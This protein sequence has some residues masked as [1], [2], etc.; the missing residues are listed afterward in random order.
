MFGS[1]SRLG[2]LVCAAALALSV[3]SPAQASSFDFSYL[4]NDGSA[5]TG[6]LSG[7]LSGSF[8][9]NISDVHVSLNGTEFSGAHL[10]SAAWNTATQSWDNTT[11]AKISTNASLNNFILADSNVPADY[12]A[13][14]YFYFVNDPSSLGHEVFA[15]NLNTGDIALDNPANTSWSLTTAP[16]AVPVPGSYAM[17]SVGLLL[18][19]AMTRRRQA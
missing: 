15:T 2:T 3:A 13:S 14:N 12:N 5:I 16:S 19:G 11:G 17:L 4:F 18:V 6:T 9:Q 1:Q 8:V 10:F 7:D